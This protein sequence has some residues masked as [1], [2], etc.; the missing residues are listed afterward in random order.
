MSCPIFSSSFLFVRLQFQICKESEEK[1][2]ERNDEKTDRK[3]IWGE[4]REN[5]NKVKKIDIR[6]KFDALG[7]SR[8][9]KNYATIRVLFFQD[10]VY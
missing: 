2:R 10:T 1:G 6:L 4:T 5:R 3:I 9:R 8:S 7:T